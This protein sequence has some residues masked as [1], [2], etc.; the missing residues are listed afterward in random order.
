MGKFKH[1]TMFNP[2]KPSRRDREMGRIDEE[3]I[4]RGN[5]GVK[6]ETLFSEGGERASFC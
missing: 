3:L 6:W 1:K 4:Q 5:Q 2:L